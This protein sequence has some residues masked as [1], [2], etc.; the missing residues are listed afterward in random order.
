MGWAVT[1]IAV[2]AAWMVGV[3][4]GWLLRGWSTTARPVDAG[5]GQFSVEQKRTVF[6][7]LRFMVAMGQLDRQLAEQVCATLNEAGTELTGSSFS[8]TSAADE[9]SV[10]ISAVT[11]ATSEPPVIAATATERAETVVSMVVEPAPLAP[12]LAAT[13]TDATETGAT[14][15]EAV[16]VA[17]SFDVSAAAVSESPSPTVSEGVPASATALPPQRIVP[18]IVMAEVV[19]VGPAPATSLHPL[20]RPEAAETPRT[21]AAQ[22][23]QRALADVLQAFMEENNIR[24][25][26]IVSGLLIVGCSIAMVISLRREIENLSERFVYLPALLF[27]LATAAIHGAGNYTL[28]RWNLRSTSRGVLIIATLLIPINFLAAIN[29]TGTESRQVMIWDPLYLTSVAIG[30]LAFG[31][32]AYF[33]SQALLPQSRWYLWLGVLGPS[34][35]QL[36]I[37]RAPD[38]M[39]TE[40]SVCWLIVLPLASF[41]IANWRMLRELTGRRRLRVRIA[42]EAIL[43]LGMTAFAFAASL[44]LLLSQTESP[45][46]TLAMLSTPLSLPAVVVLTIGLALARQAAPTG[47]RIQGS[48]PS[49]S[50]ENQS[51]GTELFGPSSD[52]WSST[53]DQQPATLP[54]PPAQPFEQQTQLQRPIDQ[55]VQLPGWQQETEQPFERRQVEDVQPA[56]SQTARHELAQLTLEQVQTEQT[57]TE[58]SKLNEAQLQQ[59]PHARQQQPRQPQPQQQQQ[60]RTS[61]QLVGTS[62][63]LCGAFLL[64]VMI[65]LAW[66][67]AGLVIAVSAASF[68]TLSLAAVIG[69]MPVLHAAAIWAGALSV[70]VGVQTMIAYFQSTELILA[71]NFVRLMLQGSSSIVFF[72]LSLVALGFASWCGRQ[73]QPETGLAYGAGSA[74]LLVLSILLT[75]V[76]GFMKTDAEGASFAAPLLLIQGSLMLVAASQLSRLTQATWTRSRLISFAPRLTYAGSTLWL[77]ALL[78]LWKFNPAFQAW[79]LDWGSVARQPILLSLLIHGLWVSVVSWLLMLRQGGSLSLHETTSWEPLIK[80]L[81]LT[82]VASAALAIPLALSVADQRYGEHAAYLTVIAVIWLQASFL[83]RTKELFAKWAFAIG[84]LATTVAVSYGTTFLCQQQ[85]AWDDRWNSPWHIQAQVVALALSCLGWNLARIRWRQGFARLHLSLGD[86]PIS[87]DKVLLGCLSVVFF[88]WLSFAAIAGCALELNWFSNTAAPVWNECRDVITLSGAWY[89]LAA[90][91]LAMLAACSAPMQRL[92]FWGLLL[93]TFLIPILLAGS[94]WDEL[95][96]ASALRWSVAGYGLLLTIS[97]VGWR[98]V[99]R[100]QTTTNHTI[101]ATVACLQSVFGSNG[102]SLRDDLRTWSLATTGLTVVGITTLRLVQ[103]I[104]RIPLHGPVADSWFTSIG[105]ECSYGIPL[106]ALVGILITHAILE[107][108]STW[109][110]AGAVVTQYLVNLAFL[111]S[112]VQ[113]AS[114]TWDTALTIQLW[115]VNVCGLGLYELLWLGMLQRWAWQGDRRV[116][117]FSQDRWF[118]SFLVLLLSMLI[119]LSGTATWCV[120]VEANRT[121]SVS[122]LANW[123]TFFALVLG[124]MLAGWFIRAKLNSLGVAL[125]LGLLASI[126]GPLA[127]SIDALSTSITDYHVLLVS[128]SLIATL[129]MLGGWTLPRWHLQQATASSIYW[130]TIWLILSALLAAWDIDRAPPVPWFSFAIAGWSALIAT[131]LGLRLR[132]SGY[133]YGSAFLAMLASLLLVRP[134]LFNGFL[135]QVLGRIQLASIGAM[136]IGCI[137]LWVELRSWRREGRG[138]IEP[139]IWPTLP[140]LSTRLICGMWLVLMPFCYLLTS[141]LG[142]PRVDVQLVSPLGWIMLFMLGIQ[143][144][145]LLFDP[146]AR[147]TSLTLFGFS[148]LTILMVLDSWDEVANWSAS[149]MIVVTH[150]VMSGWLG[151]SGHVWRY[152]ADLAVLARRIGIPEPVRFLRETSRWLPI[153]SLYLAAMLVLIALLIVLGYED[154]WMRVTA[155]FALLPL[156]YGIGCQ[157]Q[158]QRRPLLQWTSGCLVSLGAIFAAW[159]ELPPTWTDQAILE[160]ALRLMMV[161]AALSILAAIPLARWLRTYAPSWLEVTQRLSRQHSVAAILALMLVLLLEWNYFVPGQGVP[162]LQPYQSVVVGLVLIGLIAALLTFALSSQRD[163]LRLS[164]EQRQVYVYAAQGV[165]VLLLAHLYLVDPTLF[166]LR[167]PYWAFVTVGIAFA[168]VGVGELCHRLKLPVLAQ[169]LQR[170]GGFLPL[171]PAL[172]WWLSSAAEHA[173][174][175]QYALLLV[176]IGLLYLWL[177]MIYRSPLISVAAILAGNVAIWS[178]LA[179]Y[180]P[181]S[182]FKHPQFWL[183]PPAI[184]ILVAAQLLRQ[185][186]GE[187][188]LTAIR[189]LSLTVIYVSST[190]DIFLEGMG[191]TLWEPMLLATLAVLGMLIGIGFRIRAFLFTGVT[192]VFMAVFSM[193]WHAYTRIQHVAI[194]WAFGIALG[195][196]IL[197][198]FGLF[199]KKRSELLHWIERLKAWEK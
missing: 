140:V 11:V 28:R 56:R 34:V 32:M 42:G 68:L 58:L 111:L 112:V 7:S 23:R 141:G 74:G 137:W 52:L 37:N 17:T 57:Q 72:S 191:Q 165:A 96:M 125:L 12:R 159:A 102:P 104:E 150:L 85:A 76:I 177:S 116:I 199:E 65:L 107:R 109:F 175:G 53:T 153:V 71:G 154:R 50:R 174:T 94:F 179:D 124:G 14:A 15:R 169:P 36:I 160:R 142:M 91:L 110:A 97:L 180:E 144:V 189:Y 24:W 77:L 128:W 157:A 188:R 27:M 22:R 178:L 122:E 190:G 54:Q 59:P 92:Q 151:L 19:E 78:Q 16:P 152:G 193:I 81:S 26:E 95:A 106:L 63:A 44:G 8:P 146:R 148:L 99:D 187:Q 105:P 70:F 67:F 47:Q 88:L 168:S 108:R 64:F 186:L 35:G 13:K 62:L 45:R 158:Q 4:F 18:E 25:G 100:L 115:Q 89:A 46:I 73:K 40:T 171:L 79:C 9:Q 126:A 39:L 172:G 127:L 103:A 120:L 198:L 30:I 138:F 2:L 123:P 60:Q 118:S 20:D 69:R 3:G 181:L 143:L 132:H 162:F 145:G 182:L 6:Q 167:Q 90:L 43:M 87:F 119:L 75:L 61:Y 135:P 130:S 121:A 155:A 164:A 1:W 101:A 183:I 93:L 49:T 131:A 98:R 117:P 114:T 31:T 51:S 82:G 136:V 86:M 10:P 33:A 176:M 134:L 184:C 147:W 29:L 161:L 139:L 41:L 133:A 113:G 80:P 48:K 156:A 149:T 192:F 84:Q 38:S 21:T 195:L 66:P 129:G 83:H 196:I 55:Q 5:S 194:W 173:L 185:Q 166:R 170:T 163:P 197:T